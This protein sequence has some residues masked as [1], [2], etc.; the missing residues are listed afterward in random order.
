MMHDD[1]FNFRF[2]EYEHEWDDSTSV[3]SWFPA[4]CGKTKRLCALSDM[5]AGQVG[6]KPTRP[7]SQL[8]LGSTRPGQIGPV[9]L[10]GKSVYN[11]RV[12]TLYGVWKIHIIR[13]P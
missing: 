9:I 6:L 5:E 2:G 10:Y 1:D 13:E 4:Q 7:P 11:T 8:G 12:C 3:K